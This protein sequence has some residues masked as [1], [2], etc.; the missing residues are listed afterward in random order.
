MR[1][2]ALLLAFAASACASAQGGAP[3]SYGGA[4]P[5]PQRQQQASRQAPAQAT[6][7]RP[8]QAPPAEP[9][10]AASGG[11]SLA[12]FAL[13]PGDVQPYDP[14]RTPRRHRVGENESLYDIAT[15]YQIPLRALIDQ[16]RLEPPYA[17]APGREIELP[18]PRTHEVRRGESFEDVARSYNVDLRS[19][20]L[21]NRMQPPYRVRQG[22]SIVLPAVAREHVQAAPD[23]TPPAAPPHAIAG[24]GRFAWPVRG[25]LISAFGAQPGGRRLDGIEIAARE[26]DPVTAAAAGEVVYAGEDLPGYGALVLV[27]HEDGYVTAYGYGRRALVQEGQ[28]VAAGQPVAEAGGT[29]KILF[30]VR[31]GRDAV[32][33]MPLL[34]GR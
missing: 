10:W 33:P 6:A 23:H 7:Q 19:L 32:D 31:R 11:R 1:R 15:A 3:I 25:E 9:D 2:A 20:A 24:D 14:A 22:D 4:T 8:T 13:Q 28:S 30:Q 12:D 5:A 26:G 29:A 21:L 34:G 17:L 16:N 18:P 27:R